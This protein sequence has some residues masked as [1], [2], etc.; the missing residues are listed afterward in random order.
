[1]KIRC[2]S[3]WRGEFLPWEKVGSSMV[4]SLSGRKNENITDNHRLSNPGQLRANSKR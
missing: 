2:V 3:K 1:M 4:D